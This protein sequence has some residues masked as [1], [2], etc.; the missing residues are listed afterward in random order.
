MH[1]KKGQFDMLKGVIIVLVVV[2]LVIALGFLM[3]GQLNVT[4]CHQASGYINTTNYACY[5]PA[6]NTSLQTSYAVNGTVAVIGAMN[7]V[8]TWLPIIVIAVIGA[9]VFSLV[10]LF[11]GKRQE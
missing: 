3:L 4:A 6:T 11:A 5:N 8:P 9:I 7:Q 2:G 1:N 10:A